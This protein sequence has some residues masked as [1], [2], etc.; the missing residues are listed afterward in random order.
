MNVQN[1]KNQTGAPHMRRKPDS[2]GPCTHTQAVPR[3]GFHGTNDEVIFRLLSVNISFA[4]TN[5]FIQAPSSRPYSSI[6]FLARAAQQTPK[7]SSGATT[8]MPT[9]P[10]PASNGNARGHAGLQYHSRSFSSKY[11]VIF[12]SL[13]GLFLF[14]SFGLNSGGQV[15]GIKKGVGHH[16]EKHSR[17]GTPV[18][19]L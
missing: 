17:P 5:S 16:P 10:A 18:T 14:C 9:Y 13:R 3:R 19:E 11:H 1:S 8:A 6:I 4:L 12:P 7:S 15:Q 2:D